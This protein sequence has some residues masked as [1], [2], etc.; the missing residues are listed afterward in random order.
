[1]CRLEAAGL[2]L[3]TRRR[4]SR[5]SNDVGDMEN[6]GTK[7]TNRAQLSND[8]AQAIV[9]AMRLELN[10]MSERIA[11]EVIAALRAGQS[12]PVSAATSQEEPLVAE[13]VA[14]A[15]VVNGQ[16]VKFSR[17]PRVHL[18]PP[19]PQTESQLLTLE[20]A[21]IRLNI[22]VQKLRRLCREQKITH[23]RVD[24]RNYRFR[25]R[26]LDEFEKAKTFKRKGA[27]R[28]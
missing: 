4:L 27:F 8:I 2:V 11:G 17:S 20:Q 12:Q 7:P 16:P 13:S 19:N 1:V 15:S 9:A 28:D 5:P 26:D 22:S 10:Q 14:N 24:Y 21:A 18:A 6:K 23:R 3:P 25:A